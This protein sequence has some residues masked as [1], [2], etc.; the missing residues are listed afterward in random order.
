MAP[1]MK[2]SSGASPLADRRVLVVE[3]NQA[4]STALVLSL[5]NA[6][7]EVV[8]PFVRVTEALAALEA[9]PVD[10]AV[11]DVGLADDDSGD[12][13]RQLIADAIPFLF[14]TGYGSEAGL[15][16]RFPE[17]PCLG[18]PVELKVLRAALA[19]LLSS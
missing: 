7:C 13:A 16:R 19:N 10:A 17:I 11:L 14:L 6:G 5:E 8:G 12:V 15:P 4:F 3:D 9:R 2:S 18:K 1:P